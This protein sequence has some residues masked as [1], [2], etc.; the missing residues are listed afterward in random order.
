[1]L[2]E[3]QAIEK[4]KRLKTLTIGLR[5]NGGT[6]LNSNL[7]N[8]AI[9]LKSTGTSSESDTLFYNTDIEGKIKMPAKLAA[10]VC[11]YYGEKLGV[12]VDFEYQNWSNYSNEASG[13]VK[14]S[15]K[16]TSNVS[17]GGYY[18]PNYKSYKFKDRVYY[19]LGLNFGNDPRIVNGDQINNYAITGGFGLPFTYQRK[20]SHANIGFEYGK[21][22]TTTP[23]TENYFKINFGFTFNDDEWFLQRKYK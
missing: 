20:I 10:G 22:G 16:N 9:G 1:V 7:T 15:L 17:I 3:K 11:Y 13:E 6:S 18:R 21:H 12:G 4:K 23:I 14:G 19:R 5:G 2:N 8:F